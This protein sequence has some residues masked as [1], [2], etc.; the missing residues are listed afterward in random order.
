MGES[1]SALSDIR[2][3]EALGNPKRKK[4]EKKKKQ[5][6][7][8]FNDIN[9]GHENTKRNITLE[10]SKIIRRQYIYSSIEDSEA[11]LEFERNDAGLKGTV[12]NL[13]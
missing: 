12:S 10:G 7:S 6:N 8:K 5:M 9:S 1:S 3:S 2:I 13:V 4:K 11:V